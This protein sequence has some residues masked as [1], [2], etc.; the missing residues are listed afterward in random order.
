[1]CKDCGGGGICEHGRARSKCKECGGSGLCEHGR[2]RS[3]CKECGGG[4]RV[5]LLEATVVEKSTG[6][7]DPQARVP[8]V[9]ARL[10][11]GPRGGKRKR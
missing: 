4:G 5:I 3:K 6:E 8:T 7:E 11:G 1:M 10:V 9:E 2:Q